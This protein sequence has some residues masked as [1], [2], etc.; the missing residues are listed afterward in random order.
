MTPQ[1]VHYGL[2]QEVFR[3]REK[4]LLVAYEKHPERFVRKGPVPLALPQ[5]AWISPAKSAMEN[6]SLLH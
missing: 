2:A 1:L 4:V 6:E 3:A 5:A